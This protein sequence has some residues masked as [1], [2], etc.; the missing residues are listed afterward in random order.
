MTDYRITLAAQ[1]D[2]EEIVERIAADDRALALRFENTLYAAF[3]RLAEHPQLGH[4]RTDLTNRPVLF[5]PVMRQA[6]AV[7]YRASAP[8]VILRIV[9]WRRLSDSVLADEL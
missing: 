2:I 7:I 9:R 4:R 1:A 8:I 6:F 5:W 3:E